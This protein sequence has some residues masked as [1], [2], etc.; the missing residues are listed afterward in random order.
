[1]A[2]LVREDWLK[3][4]LRKTGLSIVFGWRGEKQFIGRS[5]RTYYDLGGGWTEISGV[6]FLAAGRWKFG[7]RQLKRKRRPRN[8]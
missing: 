4:T 3:R 5:V 7:K 1:M 8:E 6:A 2:L